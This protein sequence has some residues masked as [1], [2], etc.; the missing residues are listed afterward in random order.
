MRT[1]ESNEMAIATVFI[2]NSPRAQSVGRLLACAK[3]ES[4]RERERD[5]CVCISNGISVFSPHFYLLDVPYINKGTT[6]TRQHSLTI[7]NLLF[8]RSLSLS[9]SASL[10]LC[11]RIARCRFA[12]TIRTALSCSVRN[13]IYLPIA[14]QHT[15]YISVFFYFFLLL[16]FVI[17]SLD[18][19]LFTYG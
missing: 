5:V 12:L 16:I 15:K 2:L 6:A 4:E 19:I 9:L 10:S 7:F 8:Q 1:T 17:F 18:R 14:R 11:I 3:A 13:V